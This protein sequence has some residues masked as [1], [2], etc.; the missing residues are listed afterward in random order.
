MTH[1]PTIRPNVGS[2]ARPYTD[3]THHRRLFA[4]RAALA[5]RQPCRGPHRV[6]RQNGAS[7]ALRQCRCA[8][9]SSQSRHQVPFHAHQRH[10]V[11]RVYDSSSTSPHSPNAAHGP[12][13]THV[14]LRTE[15]NAAVILAFH[16]TRRVPSLPR[17]PGG[18]FKPGAPFRIPRS[19]LSEDY[20]M[21]AEFDTV[22]NPFQRGSAETTT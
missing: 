14:K 19:T 22:A 7:V 5:T 6:T 2:A 11:C 21:T 12:K 3:A 4:D 17:P 18:N 20:P 16:R 9:P 10:L 15:L 13:E 1:R 8:P